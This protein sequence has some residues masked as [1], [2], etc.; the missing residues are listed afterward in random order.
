MDIQRRLKINRVAN[1]P[2]KVYKGSNWFSINHEL[3]RYVLSRKKEIKKRFKN[4][5][6][7]DELFLQTISKNSPFKHNIVPSNLREID[8]IRGAPYTYWKA[9]YS[10]LLASDKLFA[11]K[12]STETDSE[13]IEMIFSHIMNEQNGELLCR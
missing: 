9:D 10:M 1:Y 11:R 7:A 12:F 8:W 3:A 13:I 4:S 2:F 6:C 5:K